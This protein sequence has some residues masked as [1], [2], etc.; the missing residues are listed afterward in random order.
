MEYVGLV[1]NTHG[2]A[3]VQDALLKPT[4]EQI[5]NEL[6][7]SVDELKRILQIER[8]LIPELKQA[9]DKGFIS[10]TA[11]LGICSRLDKEERR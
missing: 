7:L 11:A 9:L 4:R 6:G 3:R 5:A 1:G 10:K 2:G 8:N